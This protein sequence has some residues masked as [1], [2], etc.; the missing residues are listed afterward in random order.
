MTAELLST[1]WAVGR[2]WKKRCTGI[3]DAFIDLLLERGASV[4]NLRTAAA[5][6]R[7]DLIKGLFNSDGSLKPEAGKIDWP[8][9]ELEKSNLNCG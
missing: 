9:G 4:H 8:F 2:R 5:L 1:A 6:G 7:M 3:I